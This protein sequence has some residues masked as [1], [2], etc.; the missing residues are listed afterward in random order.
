MRVKVAQWTPYGTAMAVALVASEFTA[1]SAGQVLIQ[2]IEKYYPG[3][4]VMLISV[5]HNGFR[6]F[7]YFQTHEF[8]ALIQL[9]VLAFDEID[10]SVPPVDNSGLPF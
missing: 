6:A 3:Q 9:D 5:E 1:Q 8:L 7:A 10:M 4:A 2:R